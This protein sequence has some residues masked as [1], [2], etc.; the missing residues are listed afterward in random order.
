MVLFC[1]FSADSITFIF[2]IGFVFCVFFRWIFVNKLFTCF[3]CPY[4]VRSVLMWNLQQKCFHVKTKILAEFQI[5]ISVPLG[6]EVFEAHFLIKHFLKI[7]QFCF[8]L[9]VQQVFYVYYKIRSSYKQK[10]LLLLSQKRLSLEKCLANLLTNR[11]PP[12]RQFIYHK[13]KLLKH[14]GV[15]KPC[16]H[17]HPSPSTSNQ[18][19]SASTLLSATSSTL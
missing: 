9:S 1:R 11:F 2:N 3:K 6:F 5:C 19:I 10:F 13:G 15:A 18:V 4:L 17:F 14:K 16:T 12:K 8:T 7:S